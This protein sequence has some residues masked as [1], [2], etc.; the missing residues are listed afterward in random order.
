MKPRI[1]LK[2]VAQASGVHYS[3]VSR[4]MNPGRRAGVTREIAARVLDVANRL[5]YRTNTLASSLRTRRTHVIGVVVP[6]ITS[7][8]FPPILL[9][10]QAAL[11]DR[12]YMMI[13]GN[14][15]NDAAVHRKVVAG[16][17]DRQVDGLILATATLHD[18][19][20]E[21]WIERGA[22]L[23]L[24]NRTDETGRAPAVINDDLSGIAMAVRHVVELGHK[25]VGHIAG[26]QWLS[27]GFA[28]H[29][30]F[31]LASAEQNLT[32]GPQFIATAS[33]FT[34]QAG[35]IACLDLLDRNLGVTAI[36]AANDLLALGC[37]DALAERGLGCPDDISVTGYNDAPF[38]DMVM[39]PLTTV[40]I[41]QRQMG[42]EA[43]R[44]LL[45]KIE[46]PQSHSVD[47][48][49]RPALVV[50]KS[51]VAASVGSKRA[52]TSRRKK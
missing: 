37:Y 31:V 12:A 19:I 27:T 34:R 21:E 35:R 14:T 23:V 33:S 29:R 39:P 44:L 40:R 20:V 17:I 2:Q 36:I 47:I 30:G 9:G 52:A 22:P 26:P 7:L 24:I 18:P 32:G 50:R 49:L 11:L 15:G 5:G 10:I 4:V 8:L 1:T 41:Q 43:A 42:I 45:D 38:V 46:N 6:D 3:T 13:V 16:M 51:T 28:R 48:L 25:K